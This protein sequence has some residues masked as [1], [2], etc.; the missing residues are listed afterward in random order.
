M[1]TVGRGVV[2]RIFP[3]RGWYFCGAKRL[4]VERKRLIVISALDLV[5]IEKLPANKRFFKSDRRPKAMPI[6]ENA[7]AK[8]V[9]Y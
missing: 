2:G 4:I 8:N 1:G 3:C 6:V 9:A 7:L 5:N